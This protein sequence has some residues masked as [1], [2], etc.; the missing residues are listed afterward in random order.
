VSEFLSALQPY[1]KA[2]WGALQF[3]LDF[4]AAAIAVIALVISRRA[5]RNQA[6]LAIETLR[7][8][9]DNDGILWT[10]HVIDTL[11]GVEFLHVQR[12]VDPLRRREFIAQNQQNA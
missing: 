7:V 4:A 2:F 10:D 11:V 5:A 9:R 1:W 6:R 12:E 8:Q 3:Q